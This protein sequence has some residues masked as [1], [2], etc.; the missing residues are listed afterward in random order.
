MTTG[1][2][3]LSPVGLS[4]VTKLAPA[5]LVGVFMGL[6]F[7]APAIGNVFSG[8]IVGPMQEK[9]G[10][11]PVFLGITAIACGSAVLLMFMTPVL[12]KLMHGVK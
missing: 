1:E 11:A 4:M 3:C 6:W 2:L 5:R 9:H 10:F 8:G 7:L 12:K